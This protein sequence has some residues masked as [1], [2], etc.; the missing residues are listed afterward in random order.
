M[1]E[2][3]VCLATALMSMSTQG[4]G[5]ETC[6]AALPRI[7]GLPILQTESR[8]PRFPPIGFFFAGLNSLLIGNKNNQSLIL[9]DLSIVTGGG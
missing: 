8:V 6:S 4:A 2:M 5:L 1:W 9:L 3:K 7:S